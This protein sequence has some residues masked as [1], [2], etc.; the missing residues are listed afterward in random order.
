VHT[1]LLPKSNLV[2]LA[3]WAATVVIVSLVAPTTPWLLLGL[4]GFFGLCSRLLQ[5]RALR[6]SKSALITTQTAMDVRRALSSSRYG[7]LY[8]YALWGAVVLLLF[9]AYYLQTGGAHF[10]A[11]A[12]YA[13]F[14]ALR[15]L[16]TLRSIYELQALAAER[17]A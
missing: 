14:A 1:S 8:L 17:V 5:I 4:G 7:R 6:E 13:A 3:V 12:G 15:E 16:L 11:L 2:L 10:G 9:A